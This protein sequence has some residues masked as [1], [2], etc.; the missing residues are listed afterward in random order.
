[1][2]ELKF[3]T[4]V[5]TKVSTRGLVSISKHKYIG[6]EYTRLDLWMTPF[7][8]W[9]AGC[10][11]LWLHPNAV[12]LLGTLGLVVGHCVWWFFSPNFDSYADSPPPYWVYLVSTFSMFWS[13]T[14]DAIDGKQARRTGA[15]SPLGQLFDH[16]C[17]AFSVTLMAQMLASALDLG[18]TWMPGHFFC[19]S[20]V[21][22][23]MSTVVEYHT[24]TLPTNDGS[25]GVTEAQFVVMGHQIVTM[26]WGPSF[27]RRDLLALLPFPVG[28]LG[29]VVTPLNISL[30]VTTGQMIKFLVVMTLR[31]REAYDTDNPPSGSPCD[32]KTP[33][34]A[35]GE[36]KSPTPTLE[37]TMWGHKT[38]GF[39]RALFHLSWVGWMTAL[40][41]LW[42]EAVRGLDGDVGRVW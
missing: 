33:P 19:A 16:G 32:C 3:P 24:G 42:T 18:P 35:E 40:M 23:W 7:W 39:G 15:S 4:K 17:D 34:A 28:L 38:L 31:I 29:G 41:F 9:A 1:M 5:N 36:A 14:M 20:A 26:V 13:Q 25:L 2:G 21:M 22:F 8:N 6:G 11:P 37:E 27:W 10:L 12:T 30:L